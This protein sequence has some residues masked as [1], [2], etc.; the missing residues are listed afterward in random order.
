MGLVRWTII[1]NMASALG[2][3]LFVVVYRYAIGWHVAIPAVLLAGLVAGV[4]LL[5][6]QK[7]VGLL[8]VALS[9]ILFVPAGT[10]FVWQEASHTGEV[11]LFAA[12]FLPGIIAGWACLF[13]FGRP[14]WRALRAG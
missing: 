2:L 13:A 4:L 12:A 1:L 5:A 3:F 14:M 8:L 10:F 9:C 7:T 6:R 11:Y